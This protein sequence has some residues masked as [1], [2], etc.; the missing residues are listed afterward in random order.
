MALC[1]LMETQ[2][3]N[4]SPN[5]VYETGER[6][7]FLKDQPNMSIILYWTMSGNVSRQGIFISVLKLLEWS[8]TEVWL[9]QRSCKA[10]SQA[11]LGSQHEPGPVLSGH[12]VAISIREFN[13][14]Y[15]AAPHHLASM[16]ENSSSYTEA[17]TLVVTKHRWDFFLP[18][19]T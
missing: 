13:T 4:T 1:Y 8:L 2:K 10:R 6:K 14:T 5:N 16:P 7:H 9:N 19:C 17:T 18:Y 3:V 12:I 11:G 15:T